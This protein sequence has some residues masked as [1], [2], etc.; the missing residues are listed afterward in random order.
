[1]S[2]SASCIY[3]LY[4]TSPRDPLLIKNKG[5]ATL[6]TKILL[7]HLTFFGLL[8][9]KNYAYQQPLLHYPLPQ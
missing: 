9:L 6:I 1:M 2:T 8:C 5:Y 7:Y 3:L 4:K